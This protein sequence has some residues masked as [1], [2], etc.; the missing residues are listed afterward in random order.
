MMIYVN[1]FIYRSTNCRR[2]TPQ[3]VS[4]YV[5]ILIYMQGLLTVQVNPNLCKSVKTVQSS[6][7]VN[8]E[9]CFQKEL[10][11][12][13]IRSFCNHFICKYNWQLF[14][15]SFSHYPVRTNKIKGSV[16]T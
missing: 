3:K 11:L 5:G 6:F 2:S 12:I 9:L 16:S 10:M 1:F 7:S 15:K 4:S 14:P 8:T 13:L